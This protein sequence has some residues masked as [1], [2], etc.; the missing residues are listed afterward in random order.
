MTQTTETGIQNLTSSTVIKINVQGL[1]L[2]NLHGYF[3][4]I[5][6]VII[7]EKPEKSQDTAQSGVG[8]IAINVQQFW[9]AAI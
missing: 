9:L 3:V 8:F 1:I 5:F 4:N 6:P 7:Q 2:K